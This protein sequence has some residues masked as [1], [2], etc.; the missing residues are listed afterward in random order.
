MY[1]Y[2]EKKSDPSEALKYMKIADSE[3]VFNHIKKVSLRISVIVV[4]VDSHNAFHRKINK[5]EWFTNDFLVQ[6]IIM[7]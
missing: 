5:E 7:L 3:K 4:V 2:L 1:E 6:I